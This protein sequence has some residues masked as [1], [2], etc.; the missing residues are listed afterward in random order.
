MNKSNIL[1]KKNIEASKKLKGLKGIS[2]DELYLI[3]WNIFRKK[4]DPRDF[5]LNKIRKDVYTR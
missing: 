5:L 4:K 2:K 1:N 3:L